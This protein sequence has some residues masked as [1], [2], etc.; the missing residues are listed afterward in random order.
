MTC[1]RSMEQ[2]KKMRDSEFKGIAASKTI[3]RPRRSSLMRSSIPTDF[4][5]PD[6]CG[7]SR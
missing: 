3:W 4:I 6:D 5:R 7:V 2:M 1:L